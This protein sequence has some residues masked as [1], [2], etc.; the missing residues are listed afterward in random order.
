MVWVILAHTM[1]FVMDVHS[2]QDKERVT[3]EL[4]PSFFFVLVPT[5][6]L[7]VDC[8]FWLSGYLATFHLVAACPPPPTTGAPKGLLPCGVRGWLLLA[9][10]R[11][12]RL[13]PLYALLLATFWQLLPLAGVGPLWPHV[14]DVISQCDG[15]WWTNLL[16]VN[17][18]HPREI[19][20]SCMS[21]AWYLADDFQF[22]LA[23]PLFAA[24]YRA[25]R[26]AG[27]ALVLGLL[28][29]SLWSNDVYYFGDP[30]KER[31]YCRMAPYLYGVATAFALNGLKAPS[32]AAA[33][34]GDNERI[35]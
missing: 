12:L 24:L 8:F 17:N 25:H 34:A 11:Y 21:W 32:G 7:A 5:A 3:S 18:F 23:A 13:T 27:A 30:F 35:C 4:L 16:Y 2:I 33:A 28:V 1:Y 6:D 10:Y 19:D 14:Q 9:A 20:R 22:S 15:Y 26:P 29:V 31:P